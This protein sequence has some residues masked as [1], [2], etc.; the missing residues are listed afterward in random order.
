VGPETEPVSNRD[1]WKRLPG[2]IRADVNFRRYLVV[3]IF[4]GAG[5]MSIGFLAVY[6]V[7]RWNLP[8]SQAGGFTMAMLIG[9]AIGNLAF[10]WLS[11]RKGHKLTLEICVLT[12]ALAA[13]IAALAPQE[14]WFFLVFFMIG[15]SMA[16]MMM[17]GIMIVFEFCEPDIRP[18]YIGITNTFRGLVAIAMP[19]IGGWLAKLQGYPTMFGITFVISLLGLILL[20]FWV[21]EPRKISGL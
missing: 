3:Q 17:S 8:D 13:G 19:L 12:T 6:A 21:R 10:G 16:G 18:T 11:D 14:S 1:Y 4:T 15:V 2:I 20:R 5:N 7:Q 9:Q